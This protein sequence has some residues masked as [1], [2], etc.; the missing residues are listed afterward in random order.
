VVRENAAAKARRLLAESR[1]MVVR[2]GSD[3]LLALVRG[4]TGVLRE[5]TWDAEHGF[6]CDCPAIGPCA[7]GRAVAAVV[8]IPPGAGSWTNVASLIGGE[9]EKGA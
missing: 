7:H 4:D 3:G 8:L 1:V 9:H 5:V 2:A 6:R